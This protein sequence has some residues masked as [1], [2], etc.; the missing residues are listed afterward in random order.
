M[1][2]I[3]FIV[4]VTVWCISGYAQSTATYTFDKLGRI[5]T[6]KVESA[7]NLQFS[8]DKEGNIYSK[9]VTDIT[10][11]DEMKN[12][13]VSKL[14][15]VYPNPAN[16]VVTVEVLGT[17][18]NQEIA[19]YDILGKMLEKKVVTDSRTLFSLDGYDNG[20]YY[21]LIKSGRETVPFK[22]IKM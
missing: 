8:Y 12:P 9:D 7:Y 22:I 5:T 20:I 10:G 18:Y 6:E 19:L 14:F 11:T 1:K 2:S 3:L 21:I 16:N 17:T 15:K 13:D 4:F